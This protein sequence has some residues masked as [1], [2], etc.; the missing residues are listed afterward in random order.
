MAYTK[1]T[2]RNN[3]SPAINADNLNHIEEGVYEAHQD[4]AENT[5]NIES[6]TTQT[7]ANTSAIALEKTQR[8]QADTAE[9]LARE[10]ADNLLSARMDTFTQLPSGSTSGDAELID[11]RV[12]ADGVTYPTAGDAV[13]GQV[14]D[15]KSDIGDLTSS[16]FNGTDLD[17]ITN[18]PMSMGAIHGQ[19]YG[20][21]ADSADTAYNL[22]KVTDDDYQKLTFNNLT[23]KVAFVGY[24][25][26]GTYQTVGGWL[27]SSPIDLSTITVS[28][29]FWCVQFRRQDGSNLSASDLTSINATLVNSTENTIVYDE[30][31]EPIKNK[32]NNAT[33]FV[34]FVPSGLHR[35]ITNWKLGQIRSNFPNWT[36][37]T[38]KMTTEVPFAIKAGTKIVIASGYSII[39]IRSSGA[40]TRYNNSFVVSFNDTIWIEAN[41]TDD[42]DISTSERPVSVNVDWAVNNTAYVDGANGS[43]YND[44]SSTHPLKTIMGAINAGFRDLYVASGT[45][46]EMVDVRNIYEPISIQLW[47]M[48]T[49]DGSIEEAPKIV[50]DGGE[51]RSILYGILS[52]TNGC[53]T[54]SDIHCKRTSEAPFQLKNV[55]FAKL[56][57]CI[58]SDSAN[59][60]MGFLIN[61]CN[62]EFVDC[63]AY[64]IGQDGF[65]IHGYGNTEFV[66]CI[67]HDCGDD[68]ISHHDGCTG[69]ISGGEFYNCTKGGVASPTYGAYVDVDGV[70]SHDNTFGIYSVSEDTTRRKTKMRISNCA[71]KDNGNV[72]IFFRSATGVMWN[73]LYD[74]KTID[75]DSTLT[76][77]N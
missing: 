10:N 37:S 48:P 41:K 5:Q 51:T 2:W 75:A 23:Y 14:T 47:S 49:Y 7:G 56:T 42:S 44:G 53:L 77:L 39:V 76:E 36:S 38:N 11:I 25:T 60:K 17:E 27:T 52:N 54:L 33:E 72:D 58:A 67:A 13:R 68:G 6:L 26:D 59:D 65:N 4:I 69:R 66:N 40:A 21:H 22:T 1:T 57:R 35:V 45:Y 34:D 63:V 15:L 46:T 64:D 16:V 61:N 9:T 28:G 8:Q 74:T 29:D 18:L 31:I 32:A 19:S 24:S 55:A 43:D 73:T 62:G 30:D 3:Q 50:I 70:Y 12:G 20:N 71:L